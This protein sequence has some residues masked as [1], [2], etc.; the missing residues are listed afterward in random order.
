MPITVDAD[1]DAYA[2]TTTLRL[3][4]RYGLTVYDATYLELAQRRSLPLATLGKA[5]REAAASLDIMLLGL[6]A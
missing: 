4:E 5:L 2:W 6:E 3:A 1:T